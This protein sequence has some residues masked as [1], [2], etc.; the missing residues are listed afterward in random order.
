MRFELQILF[1]ISLDILH[2]YAILLLKMNKKYEE[3]LSFLYEIVD[4][5]FNNI[6][7]PFTD[8]ERKNNYISIQEKVAAI[9]TKNITKPITRISLKWKV[10]LINGDTVSLFGYSTIYLLAFLD[11][12]KNPSAEIYFQL[13]NI[14]KYMEFLND[15]TMLLGLCHFRGFN[16]IPELKV[17]NFCSSSLSGTI[18]AN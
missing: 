16:I 7:D 15:S 13:V 9:Y 18:L 4:Y 17:I 6:R 10:P 8:I 12:H 14:D 2:Q 1:E 5:Q 3:N 11:I